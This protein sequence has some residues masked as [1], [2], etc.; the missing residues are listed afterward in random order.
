MKSGELIFC[1]TVSLVIAGVI[2]YY[3][4]Q[5]FER[6]ASLIALKAAESKGKIGFGPSPEAA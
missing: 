6:R 1:I 3:L 2:L 5:H 4:I